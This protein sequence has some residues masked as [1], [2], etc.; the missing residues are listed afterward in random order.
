MQRKREVKEKKG[1]KGTKETMQHKREG[2]EKKGNKWKQME[3]VQGG[4]KLRKNT[5]KVGIR[6]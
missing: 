3:N 6:A 5:Y 4:E 2:K 1:T